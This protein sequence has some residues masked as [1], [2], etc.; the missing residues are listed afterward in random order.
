MDIPLKPYKKDFSHS[1]SFGVFPTIELLHHKPQSVISVLL[2]SKGE[3]NEGIE[4]L[5][6]LCQKNNIKL[7][8]NDGLIEKL[9]GNEKTYAI[10]VFKKFESRLEQDKN[11]LVLD[12]IRDMGNLGTILRTALGFGICDVAI[13]KPAADIF[14]P[15]VVRSSMG[16]LF[17][18]NFIYFATFAEYQKQFSRN[19]Y[20]FMTNGEKK[21]KDAQFLKPFSLIFGSESQGLSESFK[22]I[23]TSVSIEQTEKVDS[24]NLSIAVGIGLYESSK[25]ID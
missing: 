11:H 13:I 8:I 17:Q 16:A 12:G 23:G 25:T 1:Y 3:R 24:L 21:L 14:D 6:A 7:E 4:K 18:V 20:P 22:K 5:K 19:Y 10:G 2:H 15:K 9:A